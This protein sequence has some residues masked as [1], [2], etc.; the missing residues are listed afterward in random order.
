M[1]DDFV[2]DVCVGQG[3]KWYS[4]VKFGGN[5]QFA[6]GGFGTRNYRKYNNF[7]INVDGLVIHGVLLDQIHNLYIVHEVC[8]HI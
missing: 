7:G 3:G 8:N 1:I 2:A 4:E 6:C 5:T